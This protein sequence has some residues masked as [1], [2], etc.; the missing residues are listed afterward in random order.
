MH[1]ELAIIAHDGLPEV[2]VPGT[3]GWA[4]LVPMPA[5][6]PPFARTSSGSVTSK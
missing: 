5:A 4:V 1:V 2:V 3:A 6:V